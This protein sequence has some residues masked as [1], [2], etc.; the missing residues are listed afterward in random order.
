MNKAAILKIAKQL[1]KSKTL[2]INA[3]LTAAVIYY[4]NAHGFPMD[5]ATA[6]TLTASLFGGVN[7]L[8]RF[9]TKSG[10]MEKM[11]FLRD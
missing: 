5:E 6:A 8:L 2:T 4:A 7:W 10:V 9:L 3:A 1:M 11:T